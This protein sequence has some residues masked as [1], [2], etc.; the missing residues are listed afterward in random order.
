MRAL[1]LLLQVVLSFVLA[2]SLTPV[3][4]V[5]VPPA[6]EG[7]LGLVLVGTILVVSF[8]LLRLIWPRR[9]R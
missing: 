5:T 4:L 2:A 3:I 8:V 6:R 9:V 7:S 1:A